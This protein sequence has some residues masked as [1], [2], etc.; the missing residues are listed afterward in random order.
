MSRCLSLK[1]GNLSH[2]IGKMRGETDLV[3][4][5]KIYEM[6]NIKSLILG[7]PSSVLLSL[8]TQQKFDSYTLHH[9]IR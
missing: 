8:L 3:K 7:V 5:C 1:L 2:I 9:Q 4:Y 6:I